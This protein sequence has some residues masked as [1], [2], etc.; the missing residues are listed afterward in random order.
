MQRFQHAH[1]TPQTGLDSERTLPIN[2]VLQRKAAF[3]GPMPPFLK[4]ERFWGIWRH[5][6]K[7]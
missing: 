6:S 1:Q 7:V 3:E 4:C 2:E 5:T